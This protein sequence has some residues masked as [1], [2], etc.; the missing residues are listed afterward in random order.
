MKNI[1]CRYFHNKQLYFDQNK[2]YTRIHGQGS[3]PLF[4]SINMEKEYAGLLP[5]GTLKLGVFRINNFILT[6]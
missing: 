3:L 2:L 5:W 4:H 1:E 6:I